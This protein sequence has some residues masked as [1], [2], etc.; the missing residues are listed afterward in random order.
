MRKLT[1]MITVTPKCPYRREGKGD[2]KRRGSNAIV[3]TGT[4]MRYTLGTGRGKR[5]EGRE[6]GKEGGE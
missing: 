2:T 3:G 6:K 5:R 1:C 4:V